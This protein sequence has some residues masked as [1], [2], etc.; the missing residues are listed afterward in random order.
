MLH[1]AYTR[2]PGVC[3]CLTSSRARSSLG[4][5]NFEKCWRCLYYKHDCGKIGAEGK[6]F[7][8]TQNRL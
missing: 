5:D 2:L 8:N 6:L 4:V 7:S 3:F 1:I